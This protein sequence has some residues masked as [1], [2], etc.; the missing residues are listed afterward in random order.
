MNILHP[1][2]FSQTASHALAFA[3]ILQEVTAGTLHIVHVQENYAL[4]DGHRI[5]KTDRRFQQFEDHLQSLRDQDVQMRQDMLR[6]IRGANATSELVWGQLVRE[7]LRF[8]DRFDIAVLGTDG[9][10]RIDTFY[11]GNVASNLL[12]RATKPFVL[13]R[14]KPT[15]RI[16]QRIAVAVDFTK[17]SEHALAFAKEFNLPLTLIHVITHAR[18]SADPLYVQEASQRLSEMAGDIDVRIM[19]NRGNPIVRVPELATEAG[20]GMLVLGMRQARQG[21]GLRLGARIDGIVRS[22]AIPVMAVPLHE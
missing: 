2:D 7:L 14:N 21:I 1:T 19:L 15:S 8:Q 22:S 9:Y 10:S 13:V 12:R 6:A 20:A 4:P 11:L 18:N 16:L 5:P 17:T 3:R